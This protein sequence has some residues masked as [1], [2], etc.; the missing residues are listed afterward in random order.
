MSRSPILLIAAVSLASFWSC[1]VIIDVPA[2]CEDLNCR[3]YV[4]AE[5]AVQCLDACASNMDCGAG[6]VCD[7][8]SGDCQATGCLPQF[9]PVTLEGLPPGVNELSVSVGGAGGS[10]EQLLVLA[11]SAEGLGFRRYSVDGGLVLDDTDPD[12]G[13]IRL[14]FENVDRVPFFPTVRFVSAEQASADS[15]AARFAM[16]WRAANLTNDLVEFGTFLVDPPQPPSALT[17]HTARVRIEVDDVDFQPNGLGLLAAWTER[18]GQVGEVFTL[19]TD[20]NGNPATG[21]TPLLASPEE[22]IAAQP[23]VLSADGVYY[24]VFS[25]V[26]DGVRN[27]LA[28]AFDA[29]N[30]LIGHLRLRAD[31]P[32]VDFEIATIQGSSASR[33][34]VVFWVETSGN[35]QSMFLSYFN[36]EVASFLGIN[37]TVSLPAIRIADDFSTI[38]NLVSTDADQGFVVAWVGERD[39]QSDLW[40]QRLSEEGLVSY[41][42]MAVG[43]EDARAVTIYDITSTQDGIGVVWQENGPE[44]LTHQYQRFRCAW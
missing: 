30:T 8:N 10:D 12:L 23:E 26:G 21:S 39:G 20:L 24:V 22:R 18:A 5:D 44:G 36:A 29:N 27:V 41:S 1:S 38:S 11:A 9:A 42:P 34:A 6:Y 43:V 32:A 25:T 13:L 2:D 17:T 7:I 16:S 37:E 15:N 28:K 19:A 4:C 14:A 31:Q 33:T 40:V 35:T 3:P